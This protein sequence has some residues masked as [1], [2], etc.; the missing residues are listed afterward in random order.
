MV[1]N[2]NI[3]YTVNF[4]IY[5]LYSRFKSYYFLKGIFNLEHLTQK[6]KIF[7]VKL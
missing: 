4:E 6:N 1:N 7:I 5:G 3:K 2:C